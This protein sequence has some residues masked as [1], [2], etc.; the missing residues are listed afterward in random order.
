MGDGAPLDG[1]FCRGTRPS[2]VGTERSRGVGVVTCRRPQGR[3]VGVTNEQERG[4]LPVLRR[5]ADLVALVRERPGLY[6][7]FSA[8]PARDRGEVSRDYESGLELPGLSVSA[9]DPEG[10]W[11][12][13]LEDWLARKL[14][15]YVHLSDGRCAWV[16]EGREVAHGPDNEPLLGRWRP[17]AQLDRAVL[18]EARRRYDERF[19][20]GRFSRG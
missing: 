20:V 9:L 10:W 17:V 13:P 15:N 4:T 5:L 8:G 11:S 1:V 3:P 7:R 14:C 18:D 2:S 19:D 6:L 12:R 16:L